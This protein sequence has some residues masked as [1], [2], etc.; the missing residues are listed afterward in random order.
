MT[1]RQFIIA[2]CL[3]KL[4]LPRKKKRLQDAATELQLLREA[5]EI[6]GRNVWIKVKDLERYKDNYSAINNLLQERVEFSEKIQDIKSKIQDI[7]QNQEA[8]F[9]KI[10]NSDNNI[11]E[12]YEKQK[13]VVEKIKSEQ[14]DISDIAANIKKSFDRAT[15]KLQAIITDGDDANEILAQKTNIEQLKDKF[16]DLKDKKSFSDKK[17]AKQNAILLKISELQQ[18]SNSSYKE[19]ASGNFE[20]MGKAN[21]ALSLYRVEISALDNKIIDHY[22][23]IGK[24]ISKECYS[25][26]KCRAAVIGKFK[27]CK[28]MKSLRSSINFNQSLAEG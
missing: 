23:E 20:V 4:G 8:K 9:K 3:K 13:A 21:H 27:L 1:H 18:A 25:D 22:N 12:M 2:S 16:T 19:T 26:E 24:N 17:L 14:S 10:N 7:K 28:I 15:A 11:E 6:L 5:E